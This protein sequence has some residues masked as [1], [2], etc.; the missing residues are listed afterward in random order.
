MVTFYLIRHGQKEGGSGDPSLDKNGQMRTRHTA[1]FLKNK[2]I[3]QI[4]ASPFK[5]AI[6][7]ADIIAKELGLDMEV[8]DRLRERMNWGDKEGENYKEFWREWQK[9]DLDRDYQPSHGY[10][11]RECGRR[12]KS[13]LEDVS[14]N[15]NNNT[16][17]VVTHGGT[18][19]DLLRNVF[20]EKNLPL[21][22]NETSKAMYILIPECSVTILKKNKDFTVEK[23]GDISHL[24]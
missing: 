16:I 13:F 20:L 11:S 2:Q 18:I 14:K 19:G 12:L 10:S 22:T 8:D 24:K 3:S 6:E 1:K 9:T 7:T 5:R 23:I 15:F 21:I 4:F 17:L